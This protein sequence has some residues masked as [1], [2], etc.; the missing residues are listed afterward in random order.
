[1]T[2][3]RDQR[4]HAVTSRATGSWCTCRT[5]CRWTTRCT[6]HGW[7]LPAPS[8]SSP[9]HPDGRGTAA[10][11]LGDALLLATLIAAND[12]RT[13][14]PTSFE[15]VTPPGDIIAYRMMRCSQ[16]HAGPESRCPSGAVQAREG[17]LPTISWTAAA[18]GMA[19][20][21][22]ITPNRAPPSRTANNRP[23][24]EPNGIRVGS[25]PHDL[26]RGSHPN[27]HKPI[28][29]ADRRRECSGPDGVRWPLPSRARH[30]MRHRVVD[31]VAVDDVGQPSFH[32]PHSFHR[33]LTIEFLAVV[34][35]TSLGLVTQLDG[36]HHVQDPVD[37]PVARPGQ[38]VPDLVTGG[39]IDGCCAIPGSEVR[40][41]GKPR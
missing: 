9:G 10:A 24:L 33:G 28:G 30:R 20:R 37:L 27:C 31:H 39:R 11:G 1:V 19:T 12:A 6:R 8:R 35:G 2:P 7:P 21:A 16:A 5:R 34:V 36:G 4:Q 18:M 23:S 13:R 32:A 38:P 41:V 3:V 14:W 29:H 22:P 25:G 26:P 40:A 15:K 17:H